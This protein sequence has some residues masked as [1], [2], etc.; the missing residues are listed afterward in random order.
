M[1][2]TQGFWRMR[3]DLRA[4]F[5]AEAREIAV[6]SGSR[7]SDPADAAR[8][9]TSLTVFAPSKPI[10]HRGDTLNTAAFTVTLSAPREGVVGVRIER[11]AGE[12]KRPPAFDLARDESFRPSIAQ[13]EEYVD[14]GS[15]DL[16]ARVRRGSPWSLEF[17]ATESTPPSP[18][19]GSA[20]ASAEAARLL[21]WSGRKNVGHIEMDDGRVFTHEELALSVG[22]CVYG[23]GEQFTHFVK[24]GQTVDI[25]NEDG[26]TAS[27]FAYK[28]IPFYLTNR[29]YG[30]FVNEPGRVSFEVASE[31]VERV[32]FSVSGESLEYFIIYGPTP[33][34]ILGRYTALTG[35][36]ALPPA[37]SF[38]LWLTTSFTTQYDEQTATSFIDGMAER[39][40]PLHVFHYDCFWMREFHWCDFVWDPEVFPDPKGMLDRLHKKG[41]KSCVWI[42]PYIAQRSYLFAEGADRGYLVKR[43]NGD[44]WQWD[45]WQAGMGLVDFTNPD[46]Y[47][48]YQEKLAAL[49]D[50]GVDSFKTDFGERIPT[51]VVWH[52][53]ADPEKMH[54][55]YTLL[56]NRA[57]WEVLQEKRREACLFARSATVGGQQFPVHWGGDSTATYESMAE[58]LRGGLSLGMGG[59]GFWSHDI[60]GFEDTA[61]PDVYKRWCAFGLL[62]SHSRLHG[63]TSYRVP[64]LYDDEAVDVLRFFTKL[65]CRL[66][67]YLFAAAV[68]AHQTGVPV[69]RSMVV[70]YPDD[71]ACDYL[72]R[73]YML[74]ESILVAPVF[75]RDGTVDFYLPE[76]TW[77][78]LLDGRVVEGGRRLREQHGFFSLPVFARQGA[79]IAWG[80]SDERPDYEYAAGVT[81]TVYQPADGYRRSVSIPDTSGREAAWVSIE[82]NG[83]AVTARRSGG[84]GPWKL[85]IAGA[86]PV[87]G[88]SEELTA[89]IVE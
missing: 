87:E 53:G 74:G 9:A 83:S 65:K 27:E 82:R 39:D 7:E 81:V 14:F 64:W 38:G 4:W 6:G 10:N 35:R 25:W 73:Q 58:T 55:Y 68:T 1:K 47:R 75:S 30:V 61:A 34:Q 20:G 37:W 45:E 24:N 86:E 42:N 41:L 80:A 44:V 31:K 62:S 78:H 16:V 54:N 79:A 40:I 72:D 60:G 43:A 71:P 19:S 26:G 3:E 23:L 56:Y 88:S 21:T 84:D 8:D 5:A 69:L 2:F 57:V 89:E 46:A 51:D 22:E 67:P 15:G 63:S 49:I 36:P 18:G 28:C 32:Q 33:K 77:T 29:G 76:G 50:M 12:M 59:F 70:E 11:H 85:R 48:W 66:M 13:T 17:L 52:D